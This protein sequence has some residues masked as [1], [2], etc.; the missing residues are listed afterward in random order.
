MHF[1]FTK[2]NG[3]FGVI[4]PSTNIFIMLNAD[5][6]LL[7]SPINRIGDHADSAAVGGFIITLV[8]VSR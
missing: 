8:L 1:I 6:A 7:G 5:N 3:I 4:L 2:G